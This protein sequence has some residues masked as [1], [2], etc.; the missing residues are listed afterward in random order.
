M[1]DY[2]RA[3]AAGTH[4]SLVATPVYPQAFRIDTMKIEALT[5]PPVDPSLEIVPLSEALE[6]L[7]AAERTLLSLHCHPRDLTTTAVDAE[8][9]QRLDVMLLR[10][11][12]RQAR[13]GQPDNREIAAEESALNAEIVGR[14]APIAKRIRANQISAEDVVKELNSQRLPDVARKA[15]FTTLKSKATVLQDKNVVLAPDD[16][17]NGKISVPG[18]YPQAINVKVLHADFENNSMECRLHGFHGETSLLSSDDVGVKSL[19][20]RVPDR[21]YFFLLNQAAALDM[22]VSVTAVLD[23]VIGAKG[24]G[25][26]GRLINIKDAP[27]LA[28][29]LQLSIVER[30]KS[31]FD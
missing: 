16:E 9:L 20:I 2:P 19:S 24:F 1:R 28:Q 5:R 26:K 8:L 6:A 11:S 4:V 10:R 13:L 23:I 17:S 18:R 7:A 12:G 30:S 31:L 25:Y 3:S 14:V 27:S 22:T 15:L 29:K 21:D